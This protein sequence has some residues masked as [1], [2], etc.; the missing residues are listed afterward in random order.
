MRVLDRTILSD[1]LNEALPPAG[2]TPAES[3]GTAG[4]VIPV[5]SRTAAVGCPPTAAQWQRAMR[6]RACC[7]APPSTGP[8]SGGRSRGANSTAPVC[9]TRRSRP[10]PARGVSR[11]APGMHKI[12]APWTA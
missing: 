5:M 3:R 4:A 8:W 11:W 9:Q 12:F 7:E 1:R 10:P 6:L 2:L